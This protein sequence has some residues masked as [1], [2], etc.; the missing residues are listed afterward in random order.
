MFKILL[1]YLY[2]QI[3]IRANLITFASHNTLLN[4]YV[5][6]SFPLEYRGRGFGLFSTLYTVIYSLGSMVTG[7][8]IDK[9]GLIKNLKGGIKC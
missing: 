5:L 4:A 8:L 9:I 3:N 6:K 2:S 1:L 7:F